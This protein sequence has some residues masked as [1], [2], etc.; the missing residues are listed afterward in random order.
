MSGLCYVRWMVQ[1]EVV[2]VRVVLCEMRVERSGECQG[3]VM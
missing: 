1:G 3:C 2:S